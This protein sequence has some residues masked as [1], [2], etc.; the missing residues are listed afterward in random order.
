[1]RALAGL[2]LRRCGRRSGAIMWPSSAACW[3]SRTGAAGSG[4]CMA[5]RR[6]WR[7]RSAEWIPFPRW[8]RGSAVSAARR[9]APGARAG[10]AADG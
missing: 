10:D 4:S 3:T 8:R 2:L 5:A 1:M 9:R 7:P 6:R